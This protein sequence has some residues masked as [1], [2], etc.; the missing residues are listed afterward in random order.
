MGPALLSALLVAV[1]AALGHTFLLANLVTRR[2]RV[3]TMMTVLLACCYI[4][5]LFTLTRVG[6]AS[7]QTANNTL[8]LLVIFAAIAATFVPLRQRVTELIDRLIY[9]DRYDYARTLHELGAQLASIQ[10]LDEILSSIADDLRSAMNLSGAAILLRQSDGGF[11]VRGAS[12][13][14]RDPVKAR[15][16]VEKAAGLAPSRATERW[17]PLT[18]HEEMC[19]ILYI[20]PKCVPAD[21][22]LMTWPSSKRSPARPRSRSLTLSCWIG[23]AKRWRRWS[24]SAIAFSTSRRRSARP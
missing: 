23:C 2:A 24:C 10:P 9:R 22:T 5:L 21:L 16:V 18:A 20:G 12:G 15:L 17:I 6:F 11:M 14:C 8:A 1:C 13:D 4:L 7:T 19:G 3:Y